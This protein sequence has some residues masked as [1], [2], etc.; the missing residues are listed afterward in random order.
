MQKNHQPHKQF[1]REFGA[2]LAAHTRHDHTIQ[3]QASLHHLADYVS[4]ARRH[5][6]LSRAALAQKTGKTEADIYAL[7]QG[8]LPYSE[9]DLHFLHK[10]ADALA[11]DL[12]TLLLLLGRPALGQAVH[13]QG[14]PKSR[15]AKTGLGSSAPQSDHRPSLQRRVNQLVKGSL[16]LIDFRLAG[17]LGAWMIATRVSLIVATASVCL[18]FVWVSH[19][20]LSPYFEAKSTLQA[21]QPIAIQRVTPLPN[22]LSAR[23]VV[24][25]ANQTRSVAAP[26]HERPPQPAALAPDYGVGAR[27]EPVD[28]WRL[29]RETP[30]SLVFAQPPSIPTAQCDLRVAGRF[31]LCRV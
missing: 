30:S 18:L 4:S 22:G 3:H 13:A 5:H 10:L 1:L 27:A 19:Y 15:P 23:Q 26:P 2:L 17:R 6:H 24:V 14:T 28:N 7:E 29:T 21:D 20:S 12:E 25:P 11:E 16:N 9:L 31:A 8:L